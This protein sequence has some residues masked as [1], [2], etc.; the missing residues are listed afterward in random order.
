MNIK[1]SLTPKQNAI[2]ALSEWIPVLCLSFS[3]FIFNTTEFAPIGLLSNIANDLNITNAQTGNLITIYAWFVAL[4][5]LPFML[6][7]ANIERRKLLGILFV[8]F[9]VSHVISGLAVN[10]EMLLLSRIGIAS[11]HAVFWSITAPLAIRIAPANGKAKALGFIATG[12]SI[13]MILGLPLSRTIGLLL[14]W[15]ATFL[16]IA[17]LA[18]IGIIILMKRLPLV[19]SQHSGS[20]KSLPTLFKC[21]TLIGIY[22]L[23]I[24]IVTAHFTVYTY[25]EPFFLNISNFNPNFTTFTLLLFGLSGILGSLIYTKYNNKYPFGSLFISIT[26]ICLSLAILFPISSYPQ[27]IFFLLIFWGT[28][29]MIL[30]LSLQTKV[31][32]LAPK[33]TDIAMSIYSGIFNIGIGGGAFIGG[34]TTTHLKLSD[35]GYVGFALALVALIL[36]FLLKNSIK[37]IPPLSNQQN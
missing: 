2:S 9:I 6:I 12:S 34:L 35:I 26:I 28:S 20:L 21:P 36:C 8:I 16:C 17:L 4:S 30:G 27:L 1:P 24:I 37:K 13:A 11:S 31:L 23:T 25:I 19:P 29:T 18:I 32:Q 7:C 10:F 15:R 22:I 3:A 33:S 5:S 14:G